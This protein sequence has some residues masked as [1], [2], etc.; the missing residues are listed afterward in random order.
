[1]AL[2]F[3]PVGS[4]VVVSENAATAPALRGRKAPPSVEKTQKSA[5]FSASRI[6]GTAAL[7]GAAASVAGRRR[8]NSI[9]MKADKIGDAAA[10]LTKKAYPF[11]QKVNWD[12][13]EYLL[14]PGKADPIGWAK[15]IGKI[16]D[17]GVSMDSGLVQAGCHAHNAAIAGKSGSVCSEAQLTAINAAIGRMIASVPEEKTMDVYHTVS[18]LVDPNVPAY[19]MSKVN[20]ADAK[21]AYEALLEFV[22]V[23]KANPITPADTTT[24][25]SSTAASSIS[26]AASHLSRAAYPFMKNVDWTDDL[27]AKPPP[28]KGAQEVM[29][30]VDKM[31]AMGAKMDGAALKE[32][33]SAHVKAIEHMDDK[34]V[35]TAADLEAIL[36]GLGKAI[37]SVPEDTVMGVYSEMRN[38]VGES[39][40]KVPQYLFAKQNPLEAMEAY[41]ALMQFKDTVRAN[42]PDAIGDAAAKLASASYPFMQEVPWNSEEFLLTPGQSDPVRWAKAIGK[43]IDMGA[44]MDAGLVKAGCRAHHDAITGLPS[45]GVCSEGQLAAIYAGI[46]RMIA[47]VPESKTMQVYSAFKAI[48]DPNVPEYLMS[49][50]SEKNAK[51]AYDAL[52]EFVA[53][54]KANPIK[55]FKPKSTVSDSAA[56][57][58][59]DAAS[60]LAKAAYPF[61]KGVDWTDD[62]YQKP[63][64][65]KSAQDVMKAVDKMIV[66]GSDMDGA[67]LQEAAQA[68]VKAINNMDSKG[69]LKPK[70][71]EAILAGLGKAIS[72]VPEATV[73]GVYD[74]MRNVVGEESGAIPQ[75]LFAKQNPADAMAAYSALVQFKDTVRAS[76]PDAIGAAAAKLS[77]AAYPFMKQVPWNS[78]EFL[79]TPGKADA[80][81]WA[82]AIGKIIDMGVSMDSELV[83]AGCGAHHAAMTG[84]PADGVCSESELTAIL[85]AIGRMIASVSEEKTMDVYNTVSALVDE[86]VPAYLMSKV[87]EADAKAAYEA[88]LE[89]VAVVKANPITPNTTATRVSSSDASNISAAASALAKA[90][91]PFFQGVDWTDDLYQ[92]PIPGKSAQKVMKAVD[93]MIVMGSQMDGAALKEA[94]SAHVKAIKN[95]DGKG[96]LTQGD[97]EAILAGLGKAISSVPTATVMGVYKEMGNVTGASNG[98]VIQNLFAKQNPADAMAAYSALMDFKDTVRTAQMGEPKGDYDKSL[99]K[100]A[101][102]STVAFLAVSALGVLPF[103][104]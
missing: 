67:A 37:S 72:S 78:D 79:L 70:D 23:V 86:K 99:D 88:L 68:H 71:L 54:V 48:I 85:A 64:P 69:V 35:L 50:V 20:E 100:E 101:V 14:P 57:L 87:N 4:G 24:S 55:S 15:A 31:I 102:I 36:S 26:A 21:A 82:K 66:M 97:L 41:S 90:S 17:M 93:K 75:N 96:V 89:F 47:S 61:F 19:L 42:Q 94:A 65:G 32:A 3:V 92:K 39:T 73:M 8:R 49:K 51:A 104:H 62:L 40:S 27:F 34:G 10:V 58:I 83:K 38:L 5:N 59:S 44:T 63:I 53:V 46:G 30:A 29:K 25:V 22:E 98:A 52:L 11:M 16:I 6:V 95:M 12:S 9:A 103:I 91:Y 7:A 76:Q 18:A 84:L 56:S 60:E 28:G 13:S 43:I 2:S 33:A 45:N 80:I 1:M 74:E 81:G 77:S